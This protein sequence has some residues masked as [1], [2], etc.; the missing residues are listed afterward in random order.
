VKGIDQFKRSDETVNLADF[1][2][3][4]CVSVSHALIIG[5]AIRSCKTKY[6]LLHFLPA[7]RSYGPHT[8]LVARL[9]AMQ[10]IRTVLEICCMQLI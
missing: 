8:K 6:I 9:V 7:L 5:S 2:G 1:A 3:L 10:R 4:F